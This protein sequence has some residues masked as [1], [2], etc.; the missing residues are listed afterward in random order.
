MRKVDNFNNDWKFLLDDSMEY[1]LKD[2]D[3]STWTKLNLP[4][5]W[6]IEHELSE[7]AMTGGGGGFVCAGCGWYR[8]T[9]VVDNVKADE[10][11]SILFEGA[12]MLTTVYLN[13]EKLITHAYGYTPFNV[14]I[15][16]KL[17]EGEN[18]IALRVDNS[19]QPNSRWYTGSG[20]Y[21]DVKLIRTSS[22]HFDLWGVQ[23]NTNGIYPTQDRASLELR[24]TLVNETTTPVYAFVNYRLYDQSGEVVLTAGA[25]LYLEAGETSMCETKPEISSPHLWTDKDPYLYTLVSSLSVNEE[26]V[27]EV[28]IRTGVR[29]AT[30]DC[31][32]GFVLN[33]EPVKIKGMCLHHDC[34]LSGAVGY[35]EIWER[36]LIKLKDMG[37]NGI[38]CSHN[39]PDTAFLDLCDELG[40]LVMDEIFDEW[41]LGK[42]K[43]HNYFT[44]NFSYGYNQF[45]AKYA[46]EDLLKMLRRDYNHPSVIIWSVGNEIPEQSSKDGV[47]IVKYLQDICHEEDKTRMVT[48]ACDNIASVPAWSATEEF[49]NALD[50]V[51]Y[52]YV[53]RWRNRAETFYEEDRASHPEWRMLGSENPSVSGI[54]GDYTAEGFYGSY[55][56]QILRHE[57]L[58]RFTLT[59]DYVAG[60]YLWTG[61]D[62]LG[63]TR[64]PRRGAIC[65]PIDTAG[66]EKDA[67]Y[68]FR[69][70]WNNDD[71][72][73]HL[74]PHW[75]WQGEEGTFKQVICYSNCEEVVLYL[76]GRKVARKG[77]ECPRVGAKK[78]WNDGMNTKATT[79]DL[80]L[81]FDVPYE[82]GELMA[83]GYIGG[84]MVAKRII[85]TTK[86]AVKLVV[87][88][89]VTE[90]KQGGII[91]LEIRTEDEDG[92]I[93]P[94]ANPLVKLSIDGPAHLVGMDAGDLKDLTIYSSP[95][96]KMFAGALLAVIM[97]D[98]PGEA[99]VTLEADG[100]ESYKMNFKVSK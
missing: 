78:N 18:I 51:G 28:S 27:D 84:E 24:A 63:E 58:W 56:A 92:L 64:W 16:D 87:T 69:S 48:S 43:N 9:F 70:I 99:E 20:I 82:P 41:M 73:L 23:C 49:L 91:Q 40:F 7:E 53:G 80:H 54:R 50:V 62:Y 57:A 71:I 72:T 94:T 46:K 12:Y 1:A 74:M 68:Y 15:T 2:Y 60:D 38:R 32:K 67:F 61:I 3:D 45:F 34:G 4:H 98:A 6:S 65:G 83:E 85:K 8:K 29:T 59:H 47:A 35:R 39:P 37:C 90:V 93:V 14:D 42:N 36:R 97:A 77:Y 55:E 86:E 33:G 95:E 66:F 10:K 75:N 17:V 81:T 11:L 100:L 22:I 25:G 5:D 44:K 26:V 88:T 30:F 76:N 89:D 13:G 19:H 79:N 96:R 52:N 21:R 31:D